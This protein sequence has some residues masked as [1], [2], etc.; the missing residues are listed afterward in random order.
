MALTWLAQMGAIAWVIVTDPGQAI[1]IIA[2]M[3]SLGTIW[4]VGLGVL[5]VYVYR[6]SGEKRSSPGG[7]SK[8]SF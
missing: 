5:G 7:V 8:R 1:Q 2:A 4:T 3:A 6:R